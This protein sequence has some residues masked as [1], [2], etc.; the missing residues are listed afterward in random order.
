VIEVGCWLSGTSAIAAKMLRRIGGHPHHYLAIDT[1]AGFVDEQFAH[2]QELGTPASAVAMY[3][4]NSIE[5]VR[6]LLDLL[7]RAPEVE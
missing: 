1:F 6:R 4:Q 3:G 5:M 7:G 2:E